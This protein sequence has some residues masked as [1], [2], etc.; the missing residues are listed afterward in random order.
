[1]LVATGTA[2]L[3]GGSVMLARPKIQEWKILN[4]RRMEILES[5]DK[6]RVLI[7][8]GDG[9]AKRLSALSSMLPQFP[10]DKKMDIHWLAYMDT[11]A[12]KHDVKIARRQ[13]GEEKKMGDVYELPIECKD[14]E[15]ELEPIVRF[16]FDLQSE[17]AMLDMRQLLVKP[18]AG[19]LL[20]GRFS[21]FCA[22]TRSEE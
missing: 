6:E 1:L 13:A 14:W 7:D 9:W 4:R 8:R 10:A 18:K 11:L 5:I 20:R 15:G 3:F 2:A 12:T 16:L 22:Y 19:R 21:L 17:G